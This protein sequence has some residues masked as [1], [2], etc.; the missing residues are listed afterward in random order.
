M[1]AAG[2]GANLT[3]A[4]A[5]CTQIAPLQRSVNSEMYYL[6]LGLV[7][8]QSAA[9]TCPDGSCCPWTNNPMPH[10]SQRQVARM[11]AASPPSLFSSSSSHA[12]RRICCNGPL[13][14][15]CSGDSGCAMSAEVA[16]LGS[17]AWGEGDGTVSDAVCA[18]SQ[19]NM[20]GVLMAVIKG[21]ASAGMMPCLHWTP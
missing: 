2:G 10:L 11:A 20:H 6:L 12:N 19:E 8:A 18:T 3:P 1:Q 9:G 17:A 21:S 13:G 4:A 14:R 15:A 7:D 5:C 16:V